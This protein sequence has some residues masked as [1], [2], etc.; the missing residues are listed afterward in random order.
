VS[1]TLVIVES[2]FAPRTPLPAVGC[3][4]GRLLPLGELLSEW[5]V[6]C[7]AVLHRLGESTLHARYLAAC[8]SDCLHR[9]EAPFAS[10]GLY[11]MP[12]VLDDTKPEERARGIA[13]G[14]AWRRVAT[15]TVIYLDLGWSDGMR[16]G[17]RDAL[18]QVDTERVNRRLLLPHRIEYRWLGGEWKAHWKLGGAG[19][20]L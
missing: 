6:F 16:A 18:A 14:F 15:A 13:A 9:D 20:P 2:P 8:M 7:R 19:E 17:E 12:G 11:T 1:H 5:C 10:H 3:T 4:C